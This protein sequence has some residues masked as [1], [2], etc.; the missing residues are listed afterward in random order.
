MVVVVASAA[1]AR[2]GVGEMTF[3]RRLVRHVL[4]SPMAVRRRFNAAVLQAIEAAV[5]EAERGHRGEIRFI[6]ETDLSI[7]ALWGRRTPRERAIEL[8]AMHRV[9]DTADNNGVLVYVLWADRA[10]EI[11]AD[12]GFN[13]VVT[14]AEWG[15][16]SR[17]METAFASGEW[18]A[19]AVSGVQAIGRLLDRHFPASAAESN[20]LSD[21]PLLL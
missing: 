5:T 4:Q 12:R 2:R 7:S 11:I 17:G 21:R 8:F 13:D 15:E 9:W 20:E 19:G 10:V 16:V 18:H 14:S 1:A 6:V 3:M